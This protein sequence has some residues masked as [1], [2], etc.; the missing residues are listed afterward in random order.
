MLQSA[1]PFTE[2][3][4]RAGVYCVQA[5]LRPAP[6]GPATRTPRVT[7]TNFTADMRAAVFNLQMGCLLFA[8][9][10][11]LIVTHWSLR[12]PRATPSVTGPV[13]PL[14]SPGAGW[15]TA[16]G[17]ST[18]VALHPPGFICFC[19]PTVGSDPT[20][21]SCIRSNTDSVCARCRHRSSDGG[22]LLS[23]LACP[24]FAHTH[25]VAVSPWQSDR[26]RGA[27]A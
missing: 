17:R 20:K 1:T 27:H 7:I 19:A 24:Q 5:G 13:S 15:P 16:V 25:T 8:T 11:V 4:Q 18:P 10:D 3:V 14:F 22:G 23:R 9:I 6:R 26:K 12:T 2:V 21:L